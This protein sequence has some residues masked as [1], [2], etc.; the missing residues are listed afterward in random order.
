MFWPLR[1]QIRMRFSTFVKTG[2]FSQGLVCCHCEINSILAY[3]A[4]ISSRFH[5]PYLDWVFIPSHASIVNKSHTWLKTFHDAVDFEPIL[6]CYKLYVN[7]W[8]HLCVNN[9]TYVGYDGRSYN[10]LMNQRKAAKHD[11]LFELAC[12]RRCQ[13]R[14]PSW[15]QLVCPSFERCWMIDD[16]ICI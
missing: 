10:Q 6:V 1:V 9:S 3:T 16:I 15:F 5:N 11:E 4:E 13:S 7:R 14:F 8:H 12:A 2:D